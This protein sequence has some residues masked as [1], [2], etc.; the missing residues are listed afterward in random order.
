MRFPMGNSICLRYLRELL[1]D[2]AA[3]ELSVI[4]LERRGMTMSFWPVHSAL[5]TSA[6]LER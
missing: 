5:V 1:F 4:E 6:M 2:I 3:D